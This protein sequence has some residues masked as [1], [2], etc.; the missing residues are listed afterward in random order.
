MNQITRE[1]DWGSY[2]EMLDDKVL[3]E[4]EEIIVR[5]PDGTLQQIRVHLEITHGTVSDM[6]HEYPTVQYTAYCKAKHRGVD[7]L[8]PLRGLEA[9][10]V[11]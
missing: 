11:V 10:R 1:G 7:V 5:W 4:D 8:V 3:G 9:Q 2:S 6:G